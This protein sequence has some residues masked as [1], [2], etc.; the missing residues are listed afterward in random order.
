MS[1]RGRPPV[2]P[3]VRPSGLS[4]RLSVRPAVRPSVHPS[5]RPSARPSV[6]PSVRPVGGPWAL[7][8]VRPPVRTSARLVEAV[9]ARAVE[10]RGWTVGGPW[11]SV[12]VSPYI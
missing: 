8:V 4:V 12:G 6:R 11:G 2:R 7:W 10:A 1:P 5:A 3:T 9:G